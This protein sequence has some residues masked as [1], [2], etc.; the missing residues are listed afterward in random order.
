MLGS[1][2]PSAIEIIEEGAYPVNASLLGTLSS[3]DPFSILDDDIP[4]SPTPH[5]RV[6]QLEQPHR[7]ARHPS[8]YFSPARS[9]SAMTIPITTAERLRL[10]NRHLHPNHQPRQ[11]R[12][13]HRGS[14]NPLMCPHCRQGPFDSSS[15][16]KDHRR[17]EHDISVIIR[18]SSERGSRELVQLFRDPVSNKFACRCGST[19]KST[20]NAL[21]HRKCY[22]ER[23]ELVEGM[24]MNDVDEEEGAG[25]GMIDINTANSTISV[26][27]NSSSSSATAAISGSTSTSNQIGNDESRPESF[28]SGNNQL[29]TKI[30]II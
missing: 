13:R 26:S 24:D 30:F 10:P 25:A 18:S 5:H 8:E 22:E 7:T 28:S 4:P 14:N 12:Q 27:N 23:E 16:L 29:Y 6:Q 15:K 21:Y 19:F 3:S 9:I 20:R 2:L 11:G 1:P 17:A